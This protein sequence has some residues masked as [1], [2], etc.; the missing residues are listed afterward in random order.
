M[1]RLSRLLVF[2]LVWPLYG[3]ELTDRVSNLR[4]SA[5]SSVFESGNINT[6][7]SSWGSSTSWRENLDLKH[8]NLRIHFAVE[9]KLSTFNRL[10]NNA[11]FQ[12]VNLSPR[13]NL[14]DW[15]ASLKDSRYTQSQLHV[16]RFSFEW[17]DQGLDFK[18]GRQAISFGT[19]HY[20]SVLDV[21]QP[22]SPGTLDSLY[23]PGIDAMR[24]SKPLG[25]SGE[26]E[27]I[28]APS[29]ISSQ[30][31]WFFRMRKLVRDVDVEFLA[32]RYFERNMIG[33]GFEADSPLFNGSSA[34][35]ELAFF[36]RKPGLETLRSGDSDFA[37]AMIFGID[38]YLS[39]K[40]SLTLA[41]YQ[42]DFGTSD[43]S[44][45]L[46]IATEAPFAQ[47]WHFLRSHSYLVFNV[48]R[49]LKPSVH[50]SWNNLL[51]LEDQSILI[52]PQLR[53]NLKQNL[54]LTLYSWLGYG[55]KVKAGLTRSEFADLPRQTIGFYLSSFF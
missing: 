48:N 34:W 47:G 18:L 2:F 52:Q 24:I 41:W 11:I 13:V 27:L 17:Q 50:F 45:L 7:G 12:S 31:S 44:E 38:K 39:S 25:W 20:V 28:L 32:G 26:M 23:K 40:T 46:R 21:L 4:L 42:S 14:F 5:L 6:G 36:S 22:F 1:G 35:G 8:Q 10:G 51:N 29:R 30:D 16:D 43:P 53:I 49:E 37:T 33:F 3:L 19:S 15:S 54:D 9:T 55:D